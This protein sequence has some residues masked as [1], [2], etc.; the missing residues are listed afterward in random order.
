[1]SAL[2]RVYQPGI[3]RF[4]R[5]GYPLAWDHSVEGLPPITHYVR[6]T[7][8]HRCERC[9]H[10]FRV[11]ISSAAW[12]P[13]DERCTHGGKTRK[14]DGQVEAWYRVLTVHHLNGAK[15]DCRWWNLAALCQ[16]CHLS[17]QARVI[18]E[19][20]WL[21]EHTPWFRLHAAGWYAVKYLDSDL[22]RSEV[23]ARLDELLA[24]E[25]ERT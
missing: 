17:I 5:R 3:D 19:R 7:A 23:E 20:P 18:M 9:S 22:D 4:D 15:A 10:P 14:V 21:A 16:A 13:C 11:G 12:S 8:G 24:L 2:L 6:D 25:R 1:M